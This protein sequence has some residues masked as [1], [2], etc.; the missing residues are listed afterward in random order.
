MMDS[1]D[2]IVVAPRLLASGAQL[3]EVRVPSTCTAR[4]LCAKIAA[5]SFDIEDASLLFLTY[6]GQVLV[7]ESILSDLGIGDSMSVEVVKVPPDETL[8]DYNLHRLESWHLENWDPH[9]DAK[10]FPIMLLGFHNEHSIC[11]KW[12]DETVH[13]SHDSYHARR[14]VFGVAGREPLHEL[15]DVDIST[16]HAIDGVF[17]LGRRSVEFAVK[18]SADREKRLEAL[19][20]AGPELCRGSV[21]K[22]ATRVDARFMF[23][24]HERKYESPRQPGGK[25]WPMCG[26]REVVID[27]RSGTDLGADLHRDGETVVI[28]TLHHFQSWN[29]RHPLLAVEEGACIIAVNG[30]CGDAQRILDECKEDTVLR[31]ILA[32]EIRTVPLILMAAINRSSESDSLTIQ[33]A[34]LAGNV[35]S[36]FTDVPGKDEFSTLV[37]LIEERIPPPVVRSRW[38][39]VLPSGTPGMPLSECPEDSGHYATL[40]DTALLEIF[41]FVAKTRNAGMFDLAEMF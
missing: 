12:C 35:L 5:T 36:Q 6:Q 7:A 29:D 19:V 39:L 9:R 30:M 25:G 18:A 15:R 24:R 41:G 33:C 31:I 32:D 22:G 26:E 14:C 11:I 27:R 21:P 40:L 23:K 16:D 17:Q 3:A 38:K 4:L 37:Q 34:T 8:P 10:A 28:N 20:S 1:A 2:E 13:D